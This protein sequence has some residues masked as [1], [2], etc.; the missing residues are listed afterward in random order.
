MQRAA[1]NAGK[2]VQGARG[3]GQGARKQ[4]IEAAG[5]AES[6]FLGGND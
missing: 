1:K 6:H 5:L 4:Q 2:R 3:K